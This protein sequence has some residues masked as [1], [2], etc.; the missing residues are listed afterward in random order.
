[1]VAMQAS[2]PYQDA[3]NAL[4]MPPALARVK[5][6]GTAKPWFVIDQSTF[7]PGFNLTPQRLWTIFRAAEGGSPAH[8]C[9]MFEDLVENDGHLRGQYESRMSAVAFRPW[10]VMPG[11]PDPKSVDAARVLGA[12]LARVNMLSCL[13]HLMEGLGYGWSGVN[14]AWKLEIDENTIVPGRFLCAP[15]RRFIV[16]STGTDTL[17]KPTIEPGTL[18]FLTPDQPALGVELLPGEW[19]LSQRPHRK[20][21]RAGFFRTTAWWALFKR[22]TITDWMVAAEKFGIPAIIGTYK[23]NATAESR[24]AL[25]QAVIDIGT[26]GQAVMAETCKIIVENQ[27]LRNGDL[28]ALHPTIAARCDAEVSKVVTGATLNVE[29]G[30]PGS[31]A[32]G[33]VH[34]NRAVGLSFADAFWLSSLF[35]EQVCA[36]FVEYNPRFKGAVPPRLHIRVQPEMSPRDEVAVYSQLQLMGVEIDGEQMQERFGLRPPAPG[37]ALKPLYAAKEQSAPAPSPTPKN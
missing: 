10:I 28:S 20:T 17:G 24:A 13:W 1:M 22:M 29:S 14:I 11:A 30:G 32:L 21:V 36:P 34:E 18:R 7:R 35:G 31:F 12:A 3:L 4:L 2:T 37:G 9:D 5:L 26:D 19:L 33:K 8:Q 27:A 23:E 15:H 16:T 6:G 25:N